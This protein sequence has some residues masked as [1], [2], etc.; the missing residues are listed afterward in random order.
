MDPDMRRKLRRAVALLG[1]TFILI[2]VLALRP[3]L[4]VPAGQRAVLFN[5]FRGVEQRVLGEGWNLYLPLV[6]RPELFDVRTQTYTITATA[7]D[8]VEVDS[9]PLVALSKDGQ[10]VTLDLTLLY[11]PVAEEL[12]Q[13]YREVGNKPEYEAKIVRPYLRSLA[14]MVVADNKVVELYGGSREKVEGDLKTRLDEAFRKSHLMV[15]DIQLRNLSFSKQFQDVIEKKQV[16]QQQVERM[17]YM[18][19]QAVKD[20]EKA[21]VEARG[22]AESLALVAQSLAAN[23]QLLDYEYVK[24][25]NP[26]AKAVVVQGS[27]IVNLGTLLEDKQ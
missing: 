9:F 14:R 23:P 18:L 10:P 13:L 20:K 4:V 11:R 24:N 3:V 27:T 19:L 26:N 25:L 6:Q 2:A 22:E 8:K 16:A 12:P 7:E 5:T 17:E 21:I 15:E 1:G